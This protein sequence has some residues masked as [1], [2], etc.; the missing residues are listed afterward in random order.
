MFTFGFRRQN[1]ERTSSPRK[2]FA[3]G[4]CAAQ[5]ICFSID[6]LAVSDPDQSGLSAIGDTQHRRT[7]RNALKLHDVHQTLAL[8]AA[9]PGLVCLSTQKRFQAL[10]K[11][12]DLLFIAGL[13]PE[14][15]NTKRVNSCAKLFVPDSC[16]SH[17]PHLREL[18]PYNGQN[19]QPIHFGHL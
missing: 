12:F 11:E 8:N 19:L 17:C 10:Q 16:Q 2:Q 6:Y 3:E 4:I 9:E 1:L 5:L 15:I 13:M 7:L 14:Q 18:A